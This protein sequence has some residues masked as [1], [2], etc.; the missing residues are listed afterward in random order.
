MC[1]KKT[2]VTSSG[3]GNGMRAAWMQR[4]CVHCFDLLASPKPL[5]DPPWWVDL[6]P[7]FSFSHVKFPQQRRRSAGSPAEPPHGGSDATRQPLRGQRPDGG[8]D[9]RWGPVRSITAYLIPLHWQVKTWF[10]IFLYWQRTMRP[11]HS[12]SGQKVMLG[13]YDG[14]SGVHRATREEFDAIDSPSTG[15]STTTRWR[16]PVKLK[17]NQD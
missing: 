8:A 7:S 14:V 15:I 12:F 6:L 5:H 4:L 2:L 11:L 16:S 3:R 1:F 10:F 13:C 9:R 17:R